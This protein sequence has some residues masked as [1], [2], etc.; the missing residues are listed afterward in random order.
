M[1][2]SAAAMAAPAALRRRIPIA[3]NWVFRRA[4]D[5]AWMPASVPGSNFTDLLRNGAIEAPFARDAEL[6]LQW[7]EDEDW[8]Y[9]CT[10][11]VSDEDLAADSV[12]LVFEG[13]DTCCSVVLNGVPLLRAENMFCIHR[14]ECRAL[15]RP[16]GNELAILFRSPVALGAER[17]AREGVLYPAENDKTADHA[18]VYVRKAPYHFG[19][20]WGPKYVT[21]GIWRPVWLDIV[22]T[23]RIAELRHEIVSLSPERAELAF[24][25]EIEGQAGGE[26]WLELTCDRPDVPPV[27]QPVTLAPGPGTHR[28]A[29]MVD[30]PR[31][32]WPNGLGEAHLY[33]FTLRLVDR[34]GTIDLTTQRIGLRTVEVVNQPDAHGECF[35]LKVNGRPV[36]MKGAN[37]IPQ[38]SFQEAVT[39]ERH[40]QLFRDTADANM[41]MLRVWGGGV[42]E[43][44]LFYDL[45]DEHGILIWQ[46]FMFSCTLYPSDAAFL[47]LVEEEAAQAVR[48]LRHHACLALW[49]GN[50]EISLG[51][52]HWEWP[53]KFG[54]S[55]A[56]FAAMVAGNARLFDELLPDV[57]ARLDPGRFYF[58]S[59]P[60][61][62]WNDPADDMRGDGHYWGVWHGELPFATYGERLSRFMSEYGFQSYPLLDSIQRFTAPE[63]RV[64]GSPVLSV[65]QKHA[66]GDAIIGRFVREAFGEPAGFEQ[67]CYLSQVLQ[68][69]GLRVA[70][71]AHR[72]NM[73]ICMGSLYWQLNDCWPAVS[74]S[75][76]DYYGQW[77]ALH[78]Q[79]ARSFAPVLVCAEAHEGGFR[80]HG[81]SDRMG[82][83]DAE[84]VVELV[85]FDGV[86]LWR[87]ARA[88]RIGANEARALLL[89]SA[90]DLPA[91]DRG[92]ALLTL[93]LVREGETLAANIVHP[94]MLHAAALPEPGIE[95]EILG[96]DAVRISA[97]RFARAVHVA[98][99]ALDASG[100][101]LNFDD[102][103]FDLLAGEARVVRARD[104]RR[105]DPAT[106]RV[107][108]VRDAHAIAPAPAALEGPVQR[109]AAAE[110]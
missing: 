54:Y 46:D 104:G 66:R 101:S 82:D 56:Q 105:F 11:D 55:A 6:R 33:G 23:A 94:E 44:D 43:S 97:R 78:Y 25:V 34:D 18:S 107:T 8:E 15:L 45:A 68:A 89:V 12:A 106:L 92:R 76:I 81:V 60:I 41:N 80:I 59:S 65:H 90:D 2:G 51:V 64:L 21:S 83:L 74:W 32:W 57:V 79:A 50:N 91:L 95:I 52:A 69:D 10:F 93:R 75:G 72:R 27:R 85:D 31:L 17:R 47:Q 22:R 62:H 53:E 102:N 71:E 5:A 37:Y 73:P 70:F 9:S 30:A 87:E 61:G 16:G 40:R 42:Y 100:G 103:F 48:R 108:S 58:P 28:I 63:D 109:A 13:L 24:T 110:R 26:A 14:A 84:L 35:Y 36:F 98:A 39:P 4:G 19:W 38:D 67:F 3:E 88:V 1:T 20:D 49:C 86:V 29:A 99:A 7:I 96:P 77:K